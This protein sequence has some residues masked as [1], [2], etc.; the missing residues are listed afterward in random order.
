VEEGWRWNTVDLNEVA[1]LQKG[2]GRDL[3]LLHG[4]L[5]CKETF[6]AQI[7]YFSKFYKVTA[8]DFIGFG[9][10]GALEKAFSVE[11]YA[12]WTEEVLSALGVKNPKVIAHSFGCRVAVKMAKR[13]GQVFDQLVLTGP[14]GIVLPRSGKYKRRVA[15]YRFV[16]KFA[17]KFA[18]R[19]FG[20]AEYRTLSPLMKESYKKI[21]NED[22]R[23]DAEEVACPTLVVEGREDT[24][25]TAEEAEI[26]R[27]HLPN[28]ILRFIEGGHF[29]FMENP[30]AFNLTV[31]EFFL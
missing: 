22:L 15:L 30:L 29:A 13:G 28:G 25:T 10:S 3:V 1:Y 24:V 9:K 12:V 16:K 4:Y 18:E 31:E 27:R 14:A 23:L 8:L 19:R 26:Y 5:S 17:P 6:A 2:S 21:V 7:E 20:S 11:D